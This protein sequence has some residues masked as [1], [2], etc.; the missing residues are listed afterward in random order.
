MASYYDEN[1]E[2]F[3]EA[4]RRKD[5]Q[6][7]LLEGTGLRLFISSDPENKVQEQAKADLQIII[8]RAWTAMQQAAAGIQHV[9]MTV[10]T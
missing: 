2:A 3:S 1:P 7:R 6:D 9:G 4:V 10:A 5:F 8:D